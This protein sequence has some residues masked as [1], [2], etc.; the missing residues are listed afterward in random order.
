MPTRQEVIDYITK[1]AQRHGIDPRTSLRVFQQES[2]LN[3]NANNIKT[4]KEKSW[5]IAQ[6]NTQGGLGNVARQRGIDPTDPSRWKEHVDFAHGVVAKDGWRQWYGA[7]DV[8]IGRWDGVGRGGNTSPSSPIQIANK[9]PKNIDIG[10][11]PQL[12]ELSP[13]INKM[14]INTPKGNVPLG[15]LSP[16]ETST[17][18]ARHPGFEENIKRAMAEKGVQVAGFVPPGLTKGSAKT[19]ADANANVPKKDAA[20]KS[21]V[22]DADKQIGR[23]DSPVTDEERAAIEDFNFRHE[24]WLNGNGPHPGPAPGRAE[25][26]AGSTARTTDPQTGTAVV[27]YDP[28]AAQ[29]DAARQALIAAKIR[30]TAREGGRPPPQLPPPA[31]KD[32][33]GP[34]AAAGTGAVVAGTMAGTPTPEAKKGGKIPGNAEGDELTIEHLIAQG[35]PTIKEA[36]KNPK[37]AAAAKETV[38]GLITTRAR[39]DA[40]KADVANDP[41]FYQRRA[42]KM[43]NQ[44]GMGDPGSPQY[45]RMMQDAVARDNA[46]VMARRGQP[47]Q[48]PALQ[49]VQQR[50][51]QGPPP[52]APPRRGTISIRPTP[53]S[54]RNAQPVYPQPG[55]G[56]EK[57]GGPP[58]Q[59][60]AQPPYPTAPGAGPSPHRFQQYADAPPSQALPT[61]Y[62]A[63]AES[64][65][66]HG[67]NGVPPQMN[68]QMMDPTMMQ[69]MQFF[70]QGGGGGVGN[71][72]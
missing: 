69:L 43:T 29:N 50:V 65:V 28:P 11:T 51:Q 57:G 6:L 14:T 33:V 19:R 25:P 42:S 17:N 66:N 72:P 64:V 39:Q 68:A 30:G 45:D 22:T 24:Q 15:Q 3:P 46:G 67:Y 61:G 23:K 37:T 31:N 27:P 40:A 56:Q 70:T 10:A 2:G 5:G 4:P 71:G 34:T 18:M 44:G 60:Q 1:S 16:T 35:I 20:P 47:R 52:E 26:R 63:P 49:A 12:K 9:A 7:R 54:V 21:T 8:G 38:K 36:M 55:P 58:P 48:D 41:T 53:D 59:A 62:Q 13:P 32:I